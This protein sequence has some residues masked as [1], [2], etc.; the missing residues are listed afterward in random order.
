[1]S[2]D[3]DGTIDARTPH[4]D[5]SSSRPGPG[6][7]AHG[8]GVVTPVGQSSEGLVAWTLFL[9]VVTVLPFRAG[10]SDKKRAIANFAS[11]AILWTLIFWGLIDVL[12]DFAF[13]GGR[14]L[15]LSTTQ[16]LLLVATVLFMFSGAFYWLRGRRTEGAWV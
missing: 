14:D 6:A 2:P 12:I 8:L 7:G 10:A 13:S 9:V 5:G 1:M 4:Q 11:G 16:T 3:N 15:P